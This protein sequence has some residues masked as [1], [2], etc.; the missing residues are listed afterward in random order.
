MWSMYTYICIYTYMCIYVYIHIYVYMYMYHASHFF[1]PLFID[2]H[3]G[4][5]HVLAI[6]NNPAMSMGVHIFLS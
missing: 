2:G 1:I 5:F 3:L 6:V 4:C